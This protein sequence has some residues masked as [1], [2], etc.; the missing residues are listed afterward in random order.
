MNLNHML[1]TLKF[2]KKQKNRIISSNFTAKIKASIINLF[3][4]FVITLT[5]GSR[6]TLECK[7]PWG[8]ESVFKC[9]THSHKW[10]KVQGMNPNDS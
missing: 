4:Y 10:D 5:L 6:L 2:L 1:S 8:Q 9:E 3:D 7:G